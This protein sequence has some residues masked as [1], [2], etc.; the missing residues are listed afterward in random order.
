[1]CISVQIFKDL[2]LFF[3]GNASEKKFWVGHRQSLYLT[4]EETVWKATKSL[5]SHLQSMRVPVAPHILFTFVIVS[6]LS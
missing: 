6:I 3:L 4:S 1:M 5:N 2:I